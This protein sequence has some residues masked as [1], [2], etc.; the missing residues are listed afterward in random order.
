MPTTILAKG[1]TVYEQTSIIHS[2]Y[3]NVLALKV[4]VPPPLFHAIITLH[5]MNSPLLREKCSRKESIA[6]PYPSC[7]L[8]WSSMPLFVEIHGLVF[9]NSCPRSGKYKKWVEAH[10]KILVSTTKQKTHAEQPL[11]SACLPS[12][13]HGRCTLTVHSYATW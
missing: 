7:P 8:C 1:H 13:R 4:G 9:R 2:T 12:R 11:P 3:R 5:Y 6:H 10:F